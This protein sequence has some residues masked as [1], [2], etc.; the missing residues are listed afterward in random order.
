MTYIR[1]L[2]EISY[3]GLK[4]PIRAVGWLE[5]SHRFKRGAVDREFDERLIALIQRPVGG[6]SALGMHWCSLCTAEDRIGPDCRSSQSVLLIPALNCVYETP[7]WIGHYVGR[8]SYQPP[9]EFCHAVKSCPPPGSDELRRALLGHLP[10]LVR[11]VQ[12]GM[13]FFGQWDVQVTLRPDPEY[14]SEKRSQAFVAEERL[15]AEPTP[16]ADQL[17]RKHGGLSST[18]CIWAGCKHKAL[19]TMAFCFEHAYPEYAEKRRW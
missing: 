15:K 19:A 14:G 4:G 12:D 3:S 16:S 11:F 6:L 8:H 13:P 5:S 17:I 1:D 18:T 2:A 10:G 9:D 7:I